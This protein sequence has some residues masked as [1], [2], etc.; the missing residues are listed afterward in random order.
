MKLVIGL[1][2]SL[3]LIVCVP[4]L[5]QHDHLAG[6]GD[7][8]SDN[9]SF[10]TS[11]APALRPDFNRAVALLH[12][13]WFAQAIAALRGV[14]AKDLLRDRSLG[15]RA[16][17]MGQSVC[18]TPLAAAD[19]AWAGRHS[20]GA[21]HGL[22][23]AARARVHRR[24]CRALY[25][26]GR[27]D[28]ARTHD[29]VRK[30]DGAGCPRESWRHGSA[31]LLCARGESD[32]SH[33]RQAIFAT[34][35]GRG[36]SRAALQG[37]SEVPGPCALHH[38]RLRPPA[39][40]REGARRGT[41]LRVSRRRCRTRCTCRR[42]RSRAGLVER[43]DRD[44]P[45]IAEAALKEN[46]TAEAL[47][48]MDYQTYVYLQI[49]KDAEA[50]RVADEARAAAQ[51]LDRTQRALRRPALQVC[52]PRRPSQRVTRSSGALGRKPPR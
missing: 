34:V 26:R 48:A 21:G 12:S 5:A 52:S 6:G 18:G 32:R 20:E 10:V 36:H 3:L 23:D 25:Q 27:F 44:Q 2:V 35:E 43:I 16:Q 24:G 15:H 49:A 8:G 33:N 7:V 19:R 17:P 50:R 39:A 14:A 38:P 51:R 42:I 4:V 28:A 45:A 13:F 41:Q 37:A 1:A 31:H 29:C 9:V 46:A 22:A 11:C 47:H 30:G 40:G